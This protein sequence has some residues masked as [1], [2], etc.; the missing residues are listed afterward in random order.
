MCLPAPTPSPSSSTL[1]FGIV[2]Q[3][4]QTEYTDML[5]IFV[6]SN[7][8]GNKPEKV[9]ST[10]SVNGPYVQRFSFFN[11]EED[12]YEPMYMAMLY[13]HQDPHSSSSLLLQ[14]SLRESEMINCAANE[15]AG[16]HTSLPVSG[17]A[18]THNGCRIL[19]ITYLLISNDSITH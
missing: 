12:M 7:K 11:F 8:Y 18:L 5:Q 17:A 10:G 14:L 4:V 3:Q 9:S 6:L 15:G 13:S 16:S 19:N 2:I 1:H